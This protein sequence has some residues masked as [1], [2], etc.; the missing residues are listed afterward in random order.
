MPHDAATS[1]KEVSTALRMRV[2]IGLQAAGDRHAVRPA[3]GMS[4][5]INR[6]NDRSSRA[7]LIRKNFDL[8]QHPEAA[9]GQTPRPPTATPLC[10]RMRAI[11][12]WN[13]N[14]DPFYEST[15][16]GLKNSGSVEIQWVTGHE[17]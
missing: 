3:G 16:T 9:N 13:P 7:G 14:W 12:E 8:K 17:G 2:V 11:G 5:M 4:E 15:P 10:D 6:F 1:V